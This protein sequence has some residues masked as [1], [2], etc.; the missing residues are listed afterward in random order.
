M[1]NCPKGH[2]RVRATPVSVSVT[3]TPAATTV[4]PEMS[5]TTPKI[6]LVGACANISTHASITANSAVNLRTIRRCA[7]ARSESRTGVKT[8]N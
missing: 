6:A 2:C 3:V 7:T 5:F 4:A 8:K 1:E